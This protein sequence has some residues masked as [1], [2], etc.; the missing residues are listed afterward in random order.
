MNEVLEK[1][2]H[3]PNYQWFSHLNED[4]LEE[5]LEFQ[6]YSSGEEKEPAEASI[7]PRK[8]ASS[9]K[10][11]HS[12]KKKGEGSSVQKRPP[13]KEQV[14]NKLVKQFEYYI[15]QRSLAKNEYIRKG[16][17]QDGFVPLSLIFGMKKITD[18]LENFDEDPLQILE[19]HPLLPRFK[20]KRYLIE[21]FLF[22]LGFFKVYFQ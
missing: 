11:P 14:A 6:S 17:D 5:D 7:S 9:S 2:D 10:D 20:I 19:V 8:D 13:K 21:I 3:D 22:V 15:S 18:L 4:L 12:N 16:L 1:L